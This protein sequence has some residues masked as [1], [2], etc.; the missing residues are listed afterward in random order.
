MLRDP[1]GGPGWFGGPSRRSGTV[2][3][4]LPEVRDGSGD[5]PKSGMGQGTSQSPGWVG[6]PSQ[7]FETGRETLLEVGDRLV[8][9]FRG[10]GQISGPSRR[11]RTGREVLW[12]S[13]TGQEVLPGVWDWSG[14]PFRLLGRVGEYFGRFEMGGE[15]IWKVWDG[16]EDPFG[17][18]ERV[19]GLSRRSG[20]ARGPSQGSGTGLETHSGFWDG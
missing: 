17:D 15:I 18:L 10:P 1:P 5:P 2:R 9:P 19:V 8:N 3:R 14:N 13:G 11:F 16:S 4:T 7:S 6:G 12:K 20:T